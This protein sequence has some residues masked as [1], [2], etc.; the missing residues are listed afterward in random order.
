MSQVVPHPN[1]NHT[2]ICL[3]LKISQNWT[4]S[5]PEEHLFSRMQLL[6]F[7]WQLTVP[8]LTD[9]YEGV[10]VHLQYYLKLLQHEL[11]PVSA[12]IKVIH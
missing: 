12:V 3:G 1:I 11:R 8:S 10:L 6:H 5:D 4:Y 9:S 7:P 2:E